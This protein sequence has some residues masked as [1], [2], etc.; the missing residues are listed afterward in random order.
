MSFGK[1]IFGKGNYPFNIFENL[2]LF[3]FSQK[4]CESI[5]MEMEMEIKI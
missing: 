2:F 4:K 1:F 5:K 3:F